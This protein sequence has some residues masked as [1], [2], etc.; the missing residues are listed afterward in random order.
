[1]TPALLYVM[2]EYPSVSQTFVAREAEAVRSK[3]VPVV[4]YALK[5]GQAGESSARVD[6][7]CEP[8]SRVQLGLAALRTWK[9]VPCVVRRS[10][11]YRLTLREVLRLGLAEAH[12]AYAVKSAQRLGVTHI[13]AHFL[14]RPADVASALAE[15]IGCSWSATGHAT[16]VY[17]PTE[18]HLLAARFDSASAIAGASEDIVRRIRSHLPDGETAIGLVRCGIDFSQLPEKPRTPGGTRILTI[19]RLVPK[20]GHWTTVA[21]AAELLEERPELEWL[22]V[23]DGPLKAE[24]LAD[25]R[26]KRL[27]P[28]LR[29]LGSVDNSV[30]LELLAGSTVFVLPC[31]LDPTG[32]S[33]GI[34]VALMEA[35][36]LRVPVITT[37]VGGIPELVKAGDTG[38]IVRVN[39]PVHLSQTLDWVLAH[40]RTPEMD[41]LRERAFDHVRD[42]FEIRAQATRLLELLEPY[43]GSH[44]HSPYEATRSD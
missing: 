9:R 6:L 2:H 24:L 3:R 15:R 42:E 44:P 10:W 25:P 17:S 26:V 32:D 5:K 30:A 29:F 12:A 16:D 22:V 21:A 43:L 35:M 36:A 37:E 41:A 18:P 31:E 23:G 11:R 13:H 4:G 38:F 20:K 33:D 34:P 8:P 27:S 28:R 14:S 39:D 40:S 19:G 7:M 1:M